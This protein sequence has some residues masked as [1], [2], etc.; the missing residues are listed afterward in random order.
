[1]KRQVGQNDISLRRW[2]RG[3]CCSYRLVVDAGYVGHVPEFWGLPRRFAQ[4]EGEL[5]HDRR[6]QLRILPM[7]EEEVV[8]KRF[9]LPNLLNRFVYALLR[10]S[11]AK[12]SFLYARLLRA[13]GLGSPRPVA[14]LEERLLGICLLRS[15]YVSLRSRLP[16][17]YADVAGEALPRPL[18]EQFLRAVGR[19]TARFHMAG[20]LH[21][22][23]NNGNLLLGLDAGGEAQVEL[24]D[25]NRI[26]FHHVG[27]KEGCQNMVERLDYKPWQLALLAE[28]YARERGVD[29]EQ[30]LA[31]I[32]DDKKT[33]K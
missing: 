7:G 8:V 6:N 3:R 12:R 5:I 24:V 23:Y 29:V 27:L 18:M 19:F 1:M 16:Y 26:R 28:G 25:L 17:T 31:W 33:Q 13:K 10:S 11:K 2:L 20:M 14:Y 9:A 30:C 21:K 15:Y 4:G 22:D 32:R